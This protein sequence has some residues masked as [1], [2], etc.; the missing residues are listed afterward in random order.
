MSGAVKR[1]HAMIQNARGLWD[2]WQVVLAADHDR[3]VSSLTEAGRKMQAERDQL[4]ERCR[5]LE[6]IAADAENDRARYASMARNMIL[7][8]VA[9][10]EALGIPGEEQEGGVA[11]FIEAIEHLQQA[12]QERDTLRAEVER[13]TKCLH[14]SNEQAEHFER[15]S[16]LRGDIIDRLTAD[17]EIREEERKSLCGM[18]DGQNVRIAQHLEQIERLRLELERRSGPG[19]DLKDGSDVQS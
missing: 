2:K 8:I 9:V 19:A 5:E 15:A 3:I 12:R 10:G 17:L 16:Y 4:A 14:K 11:E 6:A 1:H 18:I 13:L 7:D